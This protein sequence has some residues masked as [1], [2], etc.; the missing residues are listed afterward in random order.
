MSSEIRAGASFELSTHGIA[1]SLGL[2]TL[3]E[4]F[5]SKVQLRFDA[6]PDQQVE[7]RMTVH[8]LPGLRY[9]KMV[10]RMNVSLERPRQMLS[11]R[12]DDVCLIVSTGG[13]IAIAQRNQQSEA[14]DGE[15]VLLVYREPAVLRFQAMNYIAV[16]VPYTALAPL[17]KDIGADAGR[18][19]R[20]DT[21]ALTLLEAYLSSLPTRIA[22]PQLKGLVTTHV[23]DLMALVIGA[24]REGAEI[25]AQRSLKAARLQAIKAALANDRDLSIHEIARDQAVSPRYVQKLFEQTGTTFT[26]YVLALRLEA[27]HAMLVSPRYAH[28]TVTAISQEAGF[29]DLSYFNRRFK[30]RYDQ[31]PSGV[32]AQSAVPW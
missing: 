23:Y 1:P 20:R 24:S 18:R 22:D 25:A 11:D 12:E 4:L 26:E 21:A 7:A 30:A 9:A 31:T 14:N 17:T 15:A 2:S 8:G 32:R 19:I 28:W 6:D 27:A 13:P 3:R 29:G 5:D 10:S 16:R